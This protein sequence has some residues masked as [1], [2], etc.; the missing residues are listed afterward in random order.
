MSFILDALNKSEQERRLQKTPDL[1]SI[2]RQPTSTTQ[3]NR[4]APVIILILTVNCIGFWYWWSTT[5]TLSEPITAS[6]ATSN[7]STPTIIPEQNKTGQKIRS[8]KEVYNTTITAP[9]QRLSTTPPYLA[10][11]ISNP[12]EQLRPDVIQADVI[13]RDQLLSDKV[14]TPQDIIPASAH[15]KLV[16]ISSLPM[17]IQR[18]IPDLTFSS[19]LYSEQASFRMVNI[20]GRMLRQGDKIA[21]GIQLEEITEEGVIVSYLHYIFEISVLRDWSFN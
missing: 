4:W 2:H 17:N 20:N 13:S 1:T 19:H 11:N 7:A 10:D 14:I 9:E 6:I 3:S 18:Q 12:Q 8:R 21:A 16:R 5:S 15:P